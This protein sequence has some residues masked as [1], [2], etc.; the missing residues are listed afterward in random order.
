MAEAT[1]RPEEVM[2]TLSTEI[3]K[4]DSTMTRREDPIISSIM[5]REINRKMNILAG[6]SRIWPMMDLKLCKRD[7]RKSPLKM[8]PSQSQEDQ[9][10]Q[11]EQLEA[12]MTT[13]R[14][15]IEAATEAD[16]IIEEADTTR[17]SSRRMNRKRNEGP[18]NESGIMAFL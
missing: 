13:T 14:D 17:T 18:Y 6:I 15:N 10:L 8:C 7:Q 1:I 5:R 9:E 16:T 11:Q 2:T 12:E 4:A 3:M